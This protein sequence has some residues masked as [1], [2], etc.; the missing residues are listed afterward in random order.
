M[1]NGQGGRQ[2]A[3]ERH[4]DPGERRRDWG[5]AQARLVGLQRWGTQEGL[6]WTLSLMATGDRNR[7]RKTPGFWLGKGALSCV[8]AKNKEE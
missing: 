5:G 2:G 3:Q 8:G 6:S 4:G 7:A 1:R